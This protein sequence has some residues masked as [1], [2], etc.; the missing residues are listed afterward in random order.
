MQKPLNF[1]LCPS[2]HGA[3]LVSLLC[4]NHSQMVGLGDT[5]PHRSHLDFYCSCGKTIEKCE[6]WTLLAENTRA[7]RFVQQRHLLPIAPRL[8][9][10]PIANARLTT[11][12][13]RTGHRFGFNP[14][15]IT[16]WAGREFV[17]SIE[18]VAEFACRFH[19]TPVFLDGAKN[20]NRVIAYVMIAKPR[21][22]R[23]LHLTRDP[24]AYAYSSI[25]NNPE[26]NPSVTNAIRDWKS[27]H[28]HVLDIVSSMRGVECLTIR[29]EDLCASPN[30]TMGRIF[31]F[32]DLE[33]ETVT[34]PPTP[35]H[36]LIGNR[37]LV[38]FDG[39]V[40]LDTR[41]IEELPFE[42]KEAVWEGTENVAARLGY[43]W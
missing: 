18:D 6:F 28:S 14:W 32:F 37:M 8:R 38:G 23:I 33:N 39:K 12:M 36:H 29:Y 7:N 22:T 9:K 11:A 31:N 2:Y 25:R 15:M 10:D 13:A 21:K 41:W 3:T 34:K 30:D 16:P 40:S 43:V 4:N 20:V 35:P 19:D 1:L 24:R 5:L 17:A 26:E 42:L 27:Y